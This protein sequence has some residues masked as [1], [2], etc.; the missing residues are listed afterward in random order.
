VPLWAT[1]AG[2]ALGVTFFRVIN[3]SNVLI[4]DS[5]STSSPYTFQW[6]VRTPG[7]YTVVARSLVLVQ[8]F[9]QPFQFWSSPV[10]FTVNANP[11]G[12]ITYLHHDLAGSVI[13]AT[14]ANGAVV[15]KEDYRPYGERVVNDPASAGNRQFFTGKPLD[16]D[17]GLVYMGARYY[18]PA[19]GRFMGVDSVGF[20]IGNVHSFN[21]YAYANNNPYKFGDPDG[22][23]ATRLLY[24]EFRLAYQVAT[25]ARLGILGSRLG[26]ALYDL[27]H[28]E[29][30]QA[31][32]PVQSSDGEKSSD[33][34]KPSG[35]KS[36][37]LPTG[38]VGTQDKGARQQGNRHNSGSLDPTHGGNG[39]PQHDFDHLTGGNSGPAPSGSNYPPGTQVGENGVVLR[40]GK[41]KSGPRIDVPSNGSK[42]HETL[43]YPSGS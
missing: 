31:P 38:L 37:D 28:Q 41:G 8:G 39:D 26:G 34:S 13:G 19:V 20:A 15:W 6:N 27:M 5:P 4:A 16:Q 24:L 7:S 1:T 3:G 18:D 11:A 30:S 2:A 33:E 23:S 10:T 25:A 32:P 29:S 22:R 17:T 36:P 21:R 42:P 9:P 12:E 14:D 35:G 43:H 40:P